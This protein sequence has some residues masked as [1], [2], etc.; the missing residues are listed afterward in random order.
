MSYIK[1]KGIAIAL[2]LVLSIVFCGINTVSAT[3]R[4]QDV[5]KPYDVTVKSGSSAYGFTDG[6]KWSAVY[7]KI[8]GSAGTKQQ[9]IWYSPDGSHYYSVETSKAYKS[10]VGY[11]YTFKAN[12]KVL[13]EGENGR[14]DAA[15]IAKLYDGKL[16]KTIYS[17]KETVNGKTFDG[18]VEVET[19]ANISFENCKFN[20]GLETFGVSNVSN[21]TFT[22]CTAVNKG[23]GLTYISDTYFGHV[24]SSSGLYGQ[25]SSV[26]GVKVKSNRVSD[27]V[28]G[29]SYSESLNFPD[30]PYTYYPSTFEQKVTKQMHYDKINI[31][32]ALP[33]GLSAEDAKYDKNAHN[34][35]VN[36]K[37]IPSKA[38]ADQRFSVHFQEGISKLDITVPML[39]NV[40]TYNLEYKV[41][42]DS[43]AGFTTPDRVTGLGHDDVI[44]LNEAP[45]KVVAQKNGENGVWEFIGWSTD[46]D[47]IDSSIVTSVKMTKDTVVYGKWKFTPM[48]KLYVTKKWEGK[49]QDEAHFIVEKTVNGKASIL[50]RKDGNGN[51]IP[52][53][54]VT[55]KTEV[56]EVENEND[57][58]YR[59]IE[60]DSTGKMVKNNEIT[61]NGTKYAVSYKT[62]NGDKF[63]MLNKEVVNQGGA[64]PGKQTPDKKVPDKKAPNKHTSKKQLP[65]TGD[66]SAIWQYMLFLGSASAIICCIVRRRKID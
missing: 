21:G 9:N 51:Y 63:E 33:D 41:I 1:K 29:K 28:K 5:Y 17:G 26:V 32:G 4:T 46:K 31:V 25:T 3:S 15:T 49:K 57:T 10:G 64:L 56:I 54:V 18:P 20:A 38:G 66:D 35:V 43:P 42:G 40:N 7:E 62:E 16:T 30:F 59:I 2:S 53:K 34:T 13:Y 19:G 27:A 61:I 37:G 44:T 8:T 65:K 14:M 12:G 36:I 50:N 47:N 60:T 48:N 58:S 24:A 45:K 23:N 52:H 6:D 22:D 55:G 11:V 39:I